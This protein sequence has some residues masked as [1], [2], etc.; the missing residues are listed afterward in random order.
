MMNDDKK[1]RVFYENK[2]RNYFKNSKKFQGL[3]LE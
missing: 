1:K 3:F 2:N